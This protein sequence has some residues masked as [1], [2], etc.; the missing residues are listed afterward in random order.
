MSQLVQ[1][2]GV[3][4]QLSGSASWPSQLALWVLVLVVVTSLVLL[5]F[6]LLALPALVQKQCQ[7][8]RQ[9]VP[10]HQ[11]QHHELVRP[12]SARLGRARL[13]QLVCCLI[14]R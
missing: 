11:H 13:G 8:R 7:H 2:A 3:I 1:A 5:L 10:A 9:Q 14:V 6:R 12:S 4:A